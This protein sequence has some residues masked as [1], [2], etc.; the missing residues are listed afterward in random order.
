VGEYS[1]ALE[2]LPLIAEHPER[3]RTIGIAGYPE[4]HPLISDEALDEALRDKSRLADY[5]TTQ[6]C[7]DPEALRAWV[8][9]QREIGL[10][11]P[12]LA[13]MPGKVARR[14]LLKM[15]ARIG[16]GPSVRYL[17]KQRGLR[18]LLSRRG[19][20]DKLYDSL[21]PMLDEREL[22]LAGFQ[23]FTFNQLI[24]TWE[25]HQ[26]KFTSGKPSQTPSARRGYARG[27]ET[28]A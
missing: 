2:L 1:G 26:D 9:R 3:P 22:G 21:A 4:G 11:L 17:R 16:V 27:W 28:T 5:L 6:M 14:Q 13:G 23:Y 24:E 20:A 12:V 7:F 19:T 25:W 15:S 18:T 8:T 10:S